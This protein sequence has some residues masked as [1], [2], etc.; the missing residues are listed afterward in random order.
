V[1]AELETIVLKALEKNPADRY[2]TAGELADD[3]RRFLEDR[4]IRARRPSWAQVAAKWGRRHRPAVRAAS[5]LLVLAAALCGGVGLW[6]LQ[7]RAGAQAEARAALREAAG[8]LE[9]E[10]WPEALSAAQRA[11]GVLAGVVADPDLRRQAHRLIG[12]L[13]MAYRLQEA[14]LQGAALKD[15]HFDWGAADAA[16]AA[17]FGEYGLDVDGL[18]P[19]AAAAQIRA[20]PIHRQLVAALDDWAFNRRELKAEGWRHRLAVA[21]A[22]DPDAWRDRLRDALEGRDPKALQELAAA[23]P[24]SD[25]PGTTLALLGRLARGTASGE[26]VATLL[27]RV[28]QRHPD[29]FWINE[30]LGELLHESRPPRME[31]AIRFHSVAVALRPRSPGARLELGFALNYKGRVD[32][33]IA[34]CREAIRLNKDYALAHSNLGAALLAKGRLDEAI[35]ECREAI[36]LEPDSP[37]EHSNLGSALL[38]K[39]RLDE[40]IAECREAIRLE[41]NH[42]G[43]HHALGLALV[44]KGGLDAAIAEWRE[45]IRIEKDYAAAHCNLGAALLVKGR[46]DDAIAELREAIRLKKDNADTHSNLGTALQRKGRLD[47]AIAEYRAAIRIKKDYPDAHYGLGNALQHKGR[48]DE[49]IAAYRETIRL[50]KDDAGP[51]YDLGNALR[52][53]GR[54][55][56][57]IAEY[58]EATRIKKDYPEAHC[59]LG[60]ALVGKGEFREAVKELRLGHQLGSR[61]PRWPYPSAQWLRNAERLAATDARLPALLKGEAQPVGA[62]ERLGLAELCVLYKHLDAAAARWYG[63]AFAAQPALA[64]DLSAGHRYNAACAAALAAAGQGQDV[65]GLDEKARR[66]LRRQ[67]LDWLKDDVQAWHRLL[68]KEPDKARPVVAQQLEHWLEDTDF[69]G[70]RGAEALARLP[71]AEGQAWRQLWADVADTLAR[72]REKNRPEGK[73]PPPAVAPRKD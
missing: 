61:D 48:L 1:P 57:A 67:A 45:A 46:L 50:K 4:P 70:V 72:A 63:E 41:P 53:Q 34:E 7:Q 9:E 26:A 10:R 11:D 59:N 16:Y 13:E 14:C 23:D 29:D 62:A 65:A 24:V 66:R 5:A 20:R 68:D 47:N 27:G 8:L 69:N 22:A 58:R 36:R 54:L 21:R 55:D 17:S 38:A 19:Q 33:A 2:A 12:D 40:A 28:Q 15:G 37:G 56:E 51:H 25:W 52:G 49:A 6:W 44:Q 73:K 30:V 43:A 71:E 3:L 42:A 64:D 32:E 31:E 39:G 60:H 18:D 35:A